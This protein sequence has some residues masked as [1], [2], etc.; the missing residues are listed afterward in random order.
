MII[1]RDMHQDPVSHLVARKLNLDLSPSS[2]RPMESDTFDKIS[3][4]AA[5]GYEKIYGENFRAVYCR[6][7]RS[8]CAHSKVG[9]LV[10]E[11]FLRVSLRKPPRSRL[12]FGDMDVDV[13]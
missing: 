6:K 9:V 2:Y 7:V 1:G 10:Y 4:A 11:G 5:E 3:K 12:R 8:G 13:D